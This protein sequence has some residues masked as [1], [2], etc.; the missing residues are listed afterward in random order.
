MT[1]PPVLIIASSNAGKVREF[2]GVL[3]TG[4]GDVSV[5]IRPVPAGVE[6]EETGSTFLANACLKA[7]AAAQHCRALALADDSGL[8]VSALGNRPGLHSARYGSN[9]SERIQRLLAELGEAQERQAHFVAALAVARPDGS[10]ALTA[11]GRCDGEILEQPVGSRGFGYDPVFWVP[12]L[13]LSFAQMSPEQKR[14]Q[15]HRGRAL[16]ALLPRLAA[17]LKATGQG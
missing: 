1:S 15:S 13:G 4:L 6:V 14:Q 12:S 2:T 8:C 7:A 9:D 3:Q 17:L 5:A 16:A 10:I 11:E